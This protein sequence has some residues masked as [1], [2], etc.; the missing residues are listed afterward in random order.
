MYNCK[1]K[2]YNCE[3]NEN[4]KNMSIFSKGNIEECVYE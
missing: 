4:L 2:S 3:A 1:A